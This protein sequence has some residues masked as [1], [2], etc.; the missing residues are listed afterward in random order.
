MVSLQLASVRPGAAAQLYEEHKRTFLQ[1][2]AQC[3][4][5][6]VLFLPVVAESSGGWGESALT[7]L[8]KLA[9]KAEA[10]DGVPASL[11]MSQYL[12]GLSVVIR[13][14]SARAFLRRSGPC[15]VES[16]PTAMETTADIV[17]I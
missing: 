12:E 14:A 16:A 7:V 11:H 9:K 17:A 6:G 13:R 2:E 8:G 4:A 1:T 10:K 5:Q 15:Q 3:S